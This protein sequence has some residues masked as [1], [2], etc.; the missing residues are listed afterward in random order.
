MD[1]IFNL[2]LFADEDTA[3]PEDSNSEQQRENQEEE[4]HFDFGMDEDG[5]IHFLTNE[6]EEE[7]ENQFYSPEEMKEIG[8]DKLDPNKI[9]PELQPFYKS[10]Y[11]DYI[12][13]TQAVAE[14]RKQIESQLQQLQTPQQQEQQINPKDLQKQYYE[15]IKQIAKKRVEE[16]FGEPFDVLNEDHQTAYADEIANIKAYVVQAQT[17]KNELDRIMNYFK[18]DP[19]WQEIDK[20]ALEKIN[21]LPYAVGQQIMSA[22]NS[23]DPRFI[24]AFL[25]T[26]RQEYYNNKNP[27]K[28]PT[29]QKQAPPYVESGGTGNQNPTPQ[30][31]DF[32]KIGKMTTDQQVD[33]IRQIGL[34]KF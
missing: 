3:T 9:P 13:K 22:I 24:Y 33:F 10:M 19:E 21:S 12:R 31:P 15:N 16:V 20:Y 25:N 6:N 26:V 27:Q 23:K 32:T 5:N 34:T 4:E 29:Q 28:Q 7:Q 18:Q 30:K 17:Q 8:I 11:A 2:Q 14:Q 1:N